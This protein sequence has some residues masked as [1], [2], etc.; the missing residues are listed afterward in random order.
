M[1]Q[2]NFSFKSTSLT[3]ISVNAPKTQRQSLAF[4]V[5]H[6]VILRGLVAME[7]YLKS[8]EHSPLRFFAGEQKLENI[9]LFNF[10]MGKNWTNLFN[11]RA[12]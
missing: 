10:N 6:V 9:R 3:W 5:V 1:T 4:F 12:A 8:R 7:I 2:T 11:K